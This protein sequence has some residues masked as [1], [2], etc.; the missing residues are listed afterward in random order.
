MVTQ[1]SSDVETPLDY[2][3]DKGVDCVKENKWKISKSLKFP[4]DAVNKVVALLAA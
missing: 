2:G 4:L 3:K 1:Q